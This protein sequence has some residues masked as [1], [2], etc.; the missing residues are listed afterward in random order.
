[1]PLTISRGKVHEYLGMIFDYTN[2][3]EVKITQ[4]QFVNQIITKVP[5]IYK[6]GVGMATTAPSNLYEVRAN[7]NEDRIPLPID[8]K[9]DYH[10]LTA[11]LLYLSKRTRPDLQTSSAFHCTRVKNQDKDDQKKLARTIC[12]LEATRYLPLILS[13]LNDF[14]EW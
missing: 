12:Y 6:A 7:D 3:G 10:T 1:M 11:Q 2:T 14:I 5:E 8:E 9:E 4:Y 13:A